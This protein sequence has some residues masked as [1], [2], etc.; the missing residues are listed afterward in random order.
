MLLKAAAVWFMLM[1]L[2][3]ANGVFRNS[4]VSPRI[5]EHGGHIFSTIS[6][7]LIIL[8]VAW[9]TIGWIGPRTSRDALQVGVLWVAMTVGFEFLAGHYV[10]GNPWE[11][12]FADYNVAR[13]RIWILVLV[14]NLT[15]PRLAAGIRGLLGSPATWP[16]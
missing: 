8:I 16:Q 10:F 13:G 9:A 6:L 2:A 15:A 11:K 7:C 1:M 4:V 3:I 12:L 5:G 14:A